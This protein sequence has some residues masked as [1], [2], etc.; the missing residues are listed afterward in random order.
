M[1][2]I[3]P[4]CHWTRQRER[5]LLYCTALCNTTLTFST[6][7][8]Y[9]EDNNYYCWTRKQTNTFLRFSLT[10]HTDA[11]QI[12]ST[13]PPLLYYPLL[14]PVISIHFHQ[15]PMIKSVVPRYNIFAILKTTP[16]QMTL[17]PIRR[18]RQFIIGLD[19]SAKTVAIDI[20]P[21]HSPNRATPH[22]NPCRKGTRDP[23]LIKLPSLLLQCH[24]Q[25]SRPGPVKHTPQNLS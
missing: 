1:N 2:S 17:S 12:R 5:G 11:D 18:N 24:Y 23:L 6:M 9:R 19:I 15:Q 21:L 22:H 3:H 14:L 25:P 4:R 8:I 20:H 10:L 7:P 16:I 13:P